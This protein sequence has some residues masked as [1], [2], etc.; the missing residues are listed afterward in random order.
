MDLERAGNFA[1]EYDFDH[2]RFNPPSRN[3]VPTLGLST[4]Y[5]I[6]VVPRQS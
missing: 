4:P 2:E 5:C 3:S 1:S 6:S